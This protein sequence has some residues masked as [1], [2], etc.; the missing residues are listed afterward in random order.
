MVDFLLHFRSIVMLPRSVALSGTPDG[1]VLAARLA[2]TVNTCADVSEATEL[3][4]PQV[5]Y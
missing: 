3:F 4:E 2:S 5:S 1:N